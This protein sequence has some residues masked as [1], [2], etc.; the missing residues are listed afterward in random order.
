MKL[1]W[2][3]IAKQVNKEFKTAH[4][5]NSVRKAHTRYFN[6]ETNEKHKPRRA[7]II[8]DCH[9]PYQ[10]QKAY[11]LMLSVA[12]D[13]NLGEDDEIVIS[14]DFADFYYISRFDKKP[15]AVTLENEINAVVDRLTE[16]RDLFPKC[17]KVFIIGN[18]EFRLE[19]YLERKA[20]ELYGIVT[21]EKL[22]KLD[23]L[24]FT[25][26]QYSPSQA[27]NVLGSNL[28]ARHETFGSS[29]KSTVEAAGTSVV[30][31]HIHR[32][33]EQQIIKL[34][35]NIHT[36]YVCGWLG[37]K[38]SYVFDYVKKHH[39]WSLG[40][41]VAT[42]LNEDLFFVNNVPIIDYTCCYGGKIY[43]K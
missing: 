8:P 32:M 13:L 20:P 24:G 21:L 15:N 31:G 11:N 18:H 3:Q 6:T 10:D 33:E 37:N 27:Y 9:I 36:A 16:L 1:S 39:Q 26:V 35:G 17:K 22:F 28:I 29:A 5:D 34:D 43:T 42:V 14:G 2:A 41:A 7:L 4:T 38:N 40:F 12:K 19:K 25:C 30:C 23:E